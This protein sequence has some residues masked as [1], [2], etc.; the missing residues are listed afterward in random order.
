MTTRVRRRS[1]NLRRSHSEEQREPPPPPVAPQHVTAK[2]TA[3]LLKD[4]LA[5]RV[6][7]FGSTDAN[8]SAVDDG[9]DGAASRTSAARTKVMGR[10]E[11]VDRLPEPKTTSRSWR[12]S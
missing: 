7:V 12:I 8:G 3:P 1:M 2:K 9:V 4:E 11:G 5:T 10:G 6:N